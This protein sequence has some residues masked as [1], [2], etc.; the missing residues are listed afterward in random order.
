[1][2]TT[3]TRELVN[4]NGQDIISEA[5][6]MYTSL[7]RISD[8]INSSKSDFDSEAGDNVRKDFNASAAKFQEFETYIKSYGE[9]LETFAG[10]ILSFEN[11]VKDASS[12]IPKFGG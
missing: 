11:A 3:V 12:K 1:M 5:A 7:S 2:A 6:K 8:I 9:Y 4:A 10:N